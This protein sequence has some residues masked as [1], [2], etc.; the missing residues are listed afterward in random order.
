M[1]NTKITYLIAIPITIVLG[2]LIR[3]IKT[4][5]PDVVNLYAGDALYAVMMY[6]IVAFIVRK[7]ILYKAIIALIICYAIECSQL[8]QAD[9]INTI[10]KTLPG[11]LV[12]GSGFLYSD[13]LA[14][15]LGIV[16]AVG[17]DYLFISNPKSH[18][19]SRLK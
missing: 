11:R 12:L 10:R 8:Y 14:Y 3:S 16:V 4:I 5:L 9:W 15:F 18:N 1:S 2:L 6:Y 13:L 7:P 19:V 17:V